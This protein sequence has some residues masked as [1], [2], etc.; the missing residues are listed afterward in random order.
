MEE[1]TAV[2]IG[3]KGAGKSALYR[4][5]TNFEKSARRDAGAELEDV[6]IVS[7]TGFK[8]VANLDCPEIRNEM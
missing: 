5:F 4:Y 6:I 8:D 7:G 2:V 3:A 1:K